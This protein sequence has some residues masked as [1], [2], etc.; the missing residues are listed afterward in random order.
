MSLSQS[1]QAAA[2]L[3][4]KSRPFVPLVPVNSLPYVAFILLLGSFFG[5]FFF[6][7]LPKRNALA[8][9]I[10][11]ALISSLSAGFGVVALFNA[12]GVYV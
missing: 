10:I 11:V 1:Y 5:A 7:T 3:H 6:T 2:E 4:A 8:S 12:V 9:E